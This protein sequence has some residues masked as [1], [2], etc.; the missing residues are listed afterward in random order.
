MKYTISTHNGS[1]VSR[2]HNLRNRKITDREIHIDSTK[3]YEIWL[4]NDPKVAYQVLFDQAVKD[5]NAKQKRADRKIK[6]YYDL[7]K[8]D[9]KKHTVYEMIVS[10][11][12]MQNCPDTDITYDILKEFCRTWQKRN[13]NFVMIGCYYHADEIGVPHVHI[14]YIPIAYGYKKGLETQTGLVKALQEMGY[15]KKGKELAITQWQ[16]KQN[17]YLETLCNKR[18]LTIIHPQAGKGIKHLTTQEYVLKRQIGALKGLNQEFKIYT[19]NLQKNIECMQSYTFN[20]PS[21]VKQEGVLNKK[22]IVTDQDALKQVLLASQEAV[23]QSFDKSWQLQPSLLQQPVIEANRLLEK[24]DMLLNASL[25]NKK[26]LETNYS[27]KQNEIDKL[28]L[29]KDDLQKELNKQILFLKEIELYDFYQ[30]QKEYKTKIKDIDKI[31]PEQ[32]I[33]EKQTGEIER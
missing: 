29:E 22:L 2:Q 4:D 3:K 12:N 19:D 25:V 27:K 32:K 16:R 13:P 24:A 15:Q 23:N 8:N 11:G 30:E 20:L 18:N 28:I 9:T 21:W 14:D 5:Y 10:I 7:I 31:I 33:H 17:E 26:V 6:N 1:R